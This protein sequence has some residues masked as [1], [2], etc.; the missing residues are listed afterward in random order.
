VFREYIASS[1]NLLK[2]FKQ[3]ST[4]WPPCPILLVY[5]QEWMGN[6]NYRGFRLSTVKKV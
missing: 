5:V 6:F 1:E 4:Y 2:V 3:R